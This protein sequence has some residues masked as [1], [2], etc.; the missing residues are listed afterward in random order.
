MVPDLLSDDGIERNM[1]ELHLRRYEF[2]AR[3]VAGKRVV[4]LACGAGYGSVVLKD[5]G[6]SQVIGVD[7][8][9]DCVRYAR[10]RYARPG[11]EFMEA[12][13]MTFAPAAGC[14]VVVSLETIEHVPDARGFVTH[15]ASLLA[16]GSILVGSVPT[17]LSTDVNPYHLHDFTPRQ[18]RELFSSLGLETL[19]ELAQDQPFSPWSLLAFGSRPSRRNQL[20]KALLQYY[21]EHPSLLARRLF[22]TLRYGFCNKYLAIAARKR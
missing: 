21:I 4:D 12:D 2:A 20:R 8:S 10:E 11:I 5:A 7:V 19:D 17:T 1:L 3:F 13:G 22:T 15:L 6:A 18:F 9:P 16:P 14:D